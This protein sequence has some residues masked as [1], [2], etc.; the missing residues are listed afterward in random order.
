MATH[1]QQLTGEITTTHLT[2]RP[3]RRPVDIQVKIKRFS[4]P[5]EAAAEGVQTLPLSEL[6]FTES[7]YRIGV[8]HGVAIAF[9]HGV[10]A[11]PLTHNA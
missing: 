10:V 7:H 4:H 11:A 2:E 9:T 3:D 5:V 8:N 1:H 6:P